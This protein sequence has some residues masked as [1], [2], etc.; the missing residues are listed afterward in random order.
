[1]AKIVDKAFTLLEDMTSNILV[2]IEWSIA[3]K[4]AGLYE[5]DQFTTLPDQIVALPNQFSSFTTQG[6]GPKDSEVMAILSYG[7]NMNVL[8][9][10][11]GFTN[12]Q[13]EKKPSI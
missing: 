1:M 13:P 2:P 8:Q 9:P 12:Q 11:H 10:P 6:E 3:K 7:N 5:V 4:A